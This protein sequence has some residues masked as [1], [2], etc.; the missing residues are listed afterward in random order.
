[1]ARPIGSK[2]LRLRKLASGSVIPL[3]RG[4]LQRRLGL[5]RQRVDQLLELEGIT[6]RPG[7]RGRPEKRKTA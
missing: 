6:P 3:T 1:M 5:T 4:E 7:K 2:R